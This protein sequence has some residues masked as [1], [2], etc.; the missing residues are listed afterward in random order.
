MSVSASAGAARARVH[1]AETGAAN[2]A[3]VE[4]GL[5]RCGAAPLIVKDPQAIF[6][7]ELAIL[8]G[9][10][11]F[12]PAMARLEGSGLA[13]AFKARWKAGKPVMGICLGM[14]LFLEGSE[15]APGVPGLGL[16]R[17]VAERFR[18]SLPLP[19][20]GWNRVASDAGTDAVAGARSRLVRSGWAYFANSYRLAQAPGDFPA[21]TA[22]YGEDFVAVLESPDGAALL[23]QFHPE[24]SGPW[25][26]DLI[27]R[28]I[29]R[30][31]RSA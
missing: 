3:S 25:G 17:G 19:Q 11:A 13:D 28:W 24:L 4:A 10:G 21:G 6:D 22:R 14:Q 29:A 7:A 18:C 12:G 16:V 15:E 31:R 2:L 30:N 20:L 9:V 8:P 23:C 1:V 26:Q 5:L 27:T